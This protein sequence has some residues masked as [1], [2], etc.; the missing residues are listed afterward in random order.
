MKHRQNGRV[1]APSPGVL[2][3]T[4][5]WLWFK[6]WLRSRST[7]Q[8]LVLQ[9]LAIWALALGLV[10]YLAR[11]L[12]IHQM[13]DTLEH[14]DLALFIAANL[15]SFLIR[16]LADTYLFATL[17][18]FFHGPTG[19]WELLPASTAQYF[20]QA[21]NVLV[22]DGAMV[23]FLHQRKGVAWVT[24]GWTM[25]FQGFVDA[26]LMAGLTA[27]VGLLVPWS[28]IRRALPY[29][30]A[31]LAFFIW[32]AAWL[33]RGRS[34]TRLGRWLRSRSGMRAF[35][36]A[37]PHHYAVLGVI[38]MAIYVPNM[39]AFYLYFLSFRLHVPFAAVLALSPALMFAQSAPISP[40]GLGPLQA[41]MVDGFARFAPRNQLLTA[42]LGV[43]IVQ[44]LCRI[45][46]GAGAADTFVRGVLI[47][48]H[49][50]ERFDGG[51]DS[52]NSPGR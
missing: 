26:I 47:A 31:A 8:R 43:S 24:A 35:R 29:S 10:L 25:A 48:K 50:R 2:L 39:I 15:G 19:Y 23:L 52:T 3:S 11:G 32:A 20:L 6:E 18:S 30:L 22:A 12:S 41:V 38:R 4:Q 49:G 7:A 46:M 17:F 36:E 21:I 44:L 34:T 40:S 28:P 9:N 37:R 51:A 14:C 27:A 1:P 13:V 45:P 5:I 42:A 16:W 33:M